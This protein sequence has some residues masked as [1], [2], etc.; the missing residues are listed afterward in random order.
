MS[1]NSVDF[2]FIPD[3][4]RTVFD[5]LIMHHFISK[6]TLVDGT[7][8]SLQKIILQNSS[9]MKSGRLEKKLINKP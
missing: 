6:Y 7:A 9:F 1:K 2:T 5:R 4:T 8:L 3:N